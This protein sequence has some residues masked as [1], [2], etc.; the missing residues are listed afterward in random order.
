MEKRKVVLNAA[1]ELCNKLPNI[2]EIHYDKFSIAQ[3]KRV[4]VLT[5]HENLTLDLYSDEHD[6]RLK[7]DEK[8]KSK[9]EETIAERVK[10][11]PGK[12][13]KNRNKIR[14]FNSK[15]TFNL[16]SNIVSTNKSWKQFIQIKK[17]NQTNT[18]SFLSTQ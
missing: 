18:I 16:T 8:V 3:K 10:L 17:F 12:R 1:S 15:Q 7:D 11:N 14:I 2:Y 13:K 4:I 9:S 6:L 5:K